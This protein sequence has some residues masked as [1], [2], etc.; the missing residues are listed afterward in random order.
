[1]TAASGAPD[2]VR[3]FIRLYVLLPAALIG[4]PTFMAG[5]GFPLV[6][7][8][9]HTDLAHVGRRVGM[10]L[11]ANILGSTL[12]AFVTGW[13]LLDVLGTSGTLTLVFLLSSG[14]GALAVR[15]LAQRKGV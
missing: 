9:V 12:G 4:P 14:F 3:A 8:A 13:I 5:F 7:R 15:E 1:A 10:L 11:A 6:Q 2:V